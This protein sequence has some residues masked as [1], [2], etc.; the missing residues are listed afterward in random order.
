[1]KKVNMTKCVK[2]V[3]RGAVSG[4]LLGAFFSLS[5]CA[6]MSV[7]SKSDEVFVTLKNSGQIAKYPGQTIWQGAPVMLYNSITP[8]GKRLVASSPKNSSIYIFDTT[9]GKRLAEVKVGKASKGLKISPDGKEVYVA[10]EGEASVSVVSLNG[11]KVLATIKTEDMPHNIRFSDDG[12]FAYVTLQGGAGLGVI[13]TKTRVVTRV[14]P[15]PGIIGA[16]N[17]DLSKDGS[18]AFVR[19]TAGSVA[20]LDLQSGEIKKVIK[21]GN[22]H[23]GIDVIPNGKLVFTGAIADDVVTVIDADSFEVVKRIKVGF[24]PHGLRASI[25]NKYMYVSV[26]A[27]NKVEVIDIKTLEVVKRH[28][29]EDFP[30]WV[31]VVGNP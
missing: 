30:F 1:M 7:G 25:D 19:D 26:T 12:K 14:I 2:V 11:Y 3:K 8:D 28:N 13:D 15:T 18:I 17:L 24:G 31:A 23:A 16:H 9:S 20:I 21:V 27:D 4:F 6:V 5:A 29:V 10:N 22:G